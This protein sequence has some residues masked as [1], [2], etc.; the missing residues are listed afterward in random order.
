VAD[1]LTHAQA[2]R[3]YDRIGRWQ[4]T[5]PIVERRA[6]D[7]LLARSAFEQAEAVFEFGCGTGRLAQRLLATRLSAGCRYLGVDVSPTMVRL[8]RG[9]LTPWRDRAEVVLTDGS[10]R[11]EAADGSYDRLLSAYV[12]DLLSPRDIGA[13]LGEAQRLLRPDGLLCLT[14][15][16][17]GATRPARLVTGLWQRL[18]AVRPSVVGGCRP[19]ELAGFLAPE[20]WL[21]RER[22]TITSFGVSSQVVVA[23]RR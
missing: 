2:R 16:T 23:E 8:A 17:Y 19:V 10:L 6:V 20:S 3:V 7:E 15:L 9:R 18:W 13:L 11:F 12:L 22:L 14:S 4:D 21:L 1:Y 5:Q